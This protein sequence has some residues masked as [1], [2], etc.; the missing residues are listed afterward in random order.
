MLKSQMNASSRVTLRD[1]HLMPWVGL[2]VWQTPEEET[3]TVVKAAV[4]LGYKAV[5][6]ATLY[7][8]E[9]G[10]GAALREEPEIFITTKLWNDDQGF[11]KTLKAFDKSAH[12]LQRDVI[13]LYLIHWPMPAN[14]LYLESWKALIQLRDEGRIKSIGVS[15][16]QEEHLQHLIDETGEVPVINQ[17]ELHP[18]FQQ[19]KLRKF[20]DRHQIQTEAW[21]PLGK[22]ALLGDPVIGQIA[23]QYD[24]TPAQI[25]L[26][27]HLQ[28]GIMII[29]KSV[30]AERMK[31][32]IS[33]F[34]FELTPDD[35]EKINMLDRIDGRMGANPDNPQF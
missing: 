13:D 26:R 21:R 28:N 6:T 18:Y 8:N 25:I 33:L 29:P 2:G 10:V 22:G 14:G 27:W 4:G 9:A 1:G 11:D 35:L 12:L 19:K 7:K 23:K 3:E 24:R 30:H 34:D 15:N 5:D 20:H 32:N 16:F 17:I 31:E